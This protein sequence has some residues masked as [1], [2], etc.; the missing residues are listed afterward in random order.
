MVISAVVTGRNFDILQIK[1]YD[2]VKMV[3]IA[4]Q[5]SSLT[6]A[7][8]TVYSNADH[9]KH[10]SSAS[11]AFVRGIHRGPVNSLHKW[12]VT[13]KMFPFDDVIMTCS[14]VYESNHYR[15]Q[16]DFRFAPAIR[17]ISFCSWHYDSCFDVLANHHLLFQWHV[18]F[19][20]KLRNDDSL[21][22]LSL[23]RLTI[24]WKTGANIH[25]H[26]TV[27]VL[28]MTWWKGDLMALTIIRV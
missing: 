2:D 21:K 25:F 28:W 22:G 5:I 9:S 18:T 13:R 19:C 3:A 23:K 16:R 6:S 10:Q 27:F 12:P 24:T 8:W 14:C 7:Y 4:S 20:E 17:F 11:L 1:H 15:V 26:L